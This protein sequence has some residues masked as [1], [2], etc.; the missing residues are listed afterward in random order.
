MKE[1][2]VLLLDDNDV[3]DKYYPIQSAKGDI[4]RK[5]EFADIVIFNDTVIKNRHG[6][7]IGQALRLK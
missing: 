1:L 7:V 5:C 6:G 4:R 2:K 3:T